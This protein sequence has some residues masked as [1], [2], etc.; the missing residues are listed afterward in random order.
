MSGTFLPS[1]TCTV[2][3]THAET[4]FRIDG[5][6]CPNEAAIL[7]RR[8]KDLPGVH[9]LRADVL[10][11]RLLVSHDAARLGPIAIAQAVAETG[12]RAFVEQGRSTGG[13]AADPRRTALL[14][15]AGACVLLALVATWQGGPAATVR[16]LS[17]VAIVATAPPTLR[18]AWA[19]L[20]SRVLDINVLMT[21]A[22]AGAIALGDWTEA[23]SVT[24]LFGLAQWL[25]ARSLDRARRAIRALL[26]VGAAEATVRD[27][28]GERRVPVSEVAVGDVVLVRPGGKIPVDGTVLTG[29]SEVNQAPVTG[30]SLPVLRRRGDQVFAGTINGHGAIELRVTHAG[31]DSTLARLIHLVEQAQSK[32]APAQAFVDRFARIYTPAVLAIAACVAALPPFL[33]GWPASESVYRALVLLVIACPCAL[34]ISTPV[35]VVSALAAAARMGVLVKGGVHLE[36]AATLGSIAFD[37]TGTLTNG[38]LAVEQVVPL[39]GYRREWVLAA[40]A[41]LERRSEHPIARAIVRYAEEAGVEPLAAE[42]FRALPGRGAEA[43]IAGRDVVLGNHRLF[44]E[45]ELCSA[46][47]HEQLER[48]ENAGRIAVFLAMDGEPL[49]VIGV[50]DEPRREGPTTLDA[51]RRAGVAGLAMLTGDSERTAASIASRLGPLEVHAALLPE[52]KVRLV[53]DLRTR[54]GSVAMVGDGV[55]DAPALAAADLGIAMGAAGTDAA[56]ETADVALMGDDLS[57]VPALVD[58][59]RRTLRNIKTNIAVAL[60]LKAIF[61]ALAVAGHATLWMA[62][63]ADMGASLLV[64]ANGLRLLRVDAPAS[65]ASPAPGNGHGRSCCHT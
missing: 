45:R 25:E 47:L 23:G 46:D 28:N 50:A 38:Q 39:N 35:S 22:V 10:A 40:A 11:R 43:T 64:I 52:D 18:R 32:R 33:L 55:N 61:L 51:L 14:A 30:E 6:D 21:V 29:E 41:A 3:E 7:E 36:K 31:R 13:A 8:L 4:A 1:R 9:E 65:A 53:G 15:A 20:K 58:L 42:G 2:C 60:G 5:M 27:Q 54:F 26:D 48:V 62:V 49:G 24:F 16:V 63:V 12:M 44:H 34:V 57:K 59:G 56:L 17:L 19:S 37:K